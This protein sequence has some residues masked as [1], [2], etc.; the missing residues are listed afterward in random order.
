MSSN[1]A[2]EVGSYG[3]R[4]RAAGCLIFV[5]LPY[6]Y[7]GCTCDGSTRRLKSNIEFTSGKVP[8]LYA[9]S[10]SSGFGGI[11]CCGISSS[12]VSSSKTCSI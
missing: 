3:G 11:M 4:G 10:E 6:G 1:K 8:K 12:A 5:G 7:D 9:L 2:R